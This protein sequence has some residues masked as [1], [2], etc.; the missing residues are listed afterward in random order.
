M[1][2]EPRSQ[3]GDGEATQT[4]ATAGSGDITPGAGEV[5]EAGGVSGSQMLQQS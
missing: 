5:M 4:P 2:Q 1:M 3:T